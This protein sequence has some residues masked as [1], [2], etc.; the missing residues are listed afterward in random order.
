[1]RIFE[2]ISNQPRVTTEGILTFQELYDRDTTK[3]KSV[4]F[5]EMEYIYFSTDY[6][7]YYTGLNVDI[8]EK[9]VI[10]HY[11]KVPG[12]K[13]DA[14]VKAGVER[15]K[16]LQKTESLG[17]LEDARYA[18]EKIRGYYKSIDFAKR[19]TKGNQ[20]FKITDVTRSV[21]DIAKM[22]ESLDKLTDKVRKEEELG[23]KT[24]GDGEGGFFEN[25]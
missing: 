16:Q 11:I 5:Q 10:K 13:P 4:F 7:S 9:E 22:I 3:D 17:L 21:G 2:I 23:R 24:R 1:M 19:D 20:L 6:K 18:L 25:R 15:Y 14:L 12:W 8:R